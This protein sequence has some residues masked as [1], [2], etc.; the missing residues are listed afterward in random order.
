MLDSLPFK[1]HGP[2]F[3]ASTGAPPPP[4]ADKNAAAV[5]PKTNIRIFN[6]VKRP[7]YTGSLTAKIQM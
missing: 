5:K 6:S 2:V 7:N 1:S 4:Q 3:S